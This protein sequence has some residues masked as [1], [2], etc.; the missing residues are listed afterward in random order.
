MKATCLIVWM[1]L[2]LVLTFSI[3]GMLLFIPH[4][5]YKEGEPSTWM[6]LGRTLLTAVLNE[7]AN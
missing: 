1:I 2:T 6:H 5:D 4:V 3:V 7:K